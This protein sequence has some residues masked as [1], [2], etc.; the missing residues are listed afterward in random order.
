[1]T[2]AKAYIA[3]NAELIAHFFLAIPP[4]KT[5]SPG[6]LCSPTNVAAAICQALVPVSNHFGDGTSILHLVVFNPDPYAEVPPLR[7]GFDK[8]AVTP[9]AWQIPCLDLGHVQ[10]GGEIADIVH[11]FF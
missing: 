1:M 9:E 11:N 7:A 10:P 2:A 3:M 8:R 4:Y 5:T 6:M